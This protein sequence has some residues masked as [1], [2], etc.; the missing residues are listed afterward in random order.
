MNQPL[1]CWSCLINPSNSLKMK[2]SFVLQ[3]LF[4]SLFAC[5]SMGEDG[6]SS[7]GKIVDGSKSGRFDQNRTGSALHRGKRPPN[8]EQIELLHFLLEASPERLQT[9]RKTIERV[10]SMSPEQ[11]KSMRARLKRFRENPPATRTKMM[12]DFRMR[13]DLLR[14]YWKT[15][16][17]ETRA[18][19]MK[20]FYQLPL[21]QRPKYLEKVRKNQRAGEG[22]KPKGKE[23][24]T[25]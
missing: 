3:I 7:K 11:R 24:I 21:P 22:K 6:P 23:A 1:I 4:V 17:P 18:R 8:D 5:A 20:H 12:R 25:D 13:Q 10:E 2:I 15:L 9:I 19:E 16:D 14:K